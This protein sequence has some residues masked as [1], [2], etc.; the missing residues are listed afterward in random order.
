MIGERNFS[1]LKN[2][3]LPFSGGRRAS[4]KNI[5]TDGFVPLASELMQL[6]LL[7][8]TALLSV[9]SYSVSIGAEE[10]VWTSRKGADVTAQL[11]RVEGGEAILITPLLKT[12]TLKIEDL[13]LVD[14]LYL[15]E[16][17]GVDP[18]AVTKSEVG[19]PEKDA[20]DMSKTFERVKEKFVLGTDDDLQYDMLKTEHFYVITQGKIRPMDVAEVA[21]RLWRGMAFQHVN[22]REDWGGRRKLIFLV[23]DKKAYAKLGDWYKAHLLTLEGEHM[24][25]VAVRARMLWEESSSQT[26]YMPDQIIAKLNIFGTAKAFQ[27]GDIK[28]SYTEVFGAF[29]TH[30]LSG[31]LLSE[32]IGG[33]ADY[34]DDGAM[35]LR[36]GHAYYKEI[37]L[38]GHTETSL[39]D[40]EV[41]DQDEIVKAKGFDDGTKWAKTLRELVRKG[42]VEPSLEKLLGWQEVKDLTPESI[43]LSYSFAYYLQSTPERLNSFANMIRRVQYDGAMPVS[44]ELAKLYGFKTSKEFETDWTEFIKSQNFK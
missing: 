8:I 36:I 40:A 19:V 35:A 29:P 9:W 18:S 27:I 33:I 44:L 38:A 32:F 13:S 41:Y 2:R 12:V 37:K 24:R 43:V 25:D 39:L 7:A 31:T 5:D 22:F 21:E 14:R 1:I 10:R 4:K 34:A 6:R 17:G 3:G 16:Y 20:R 28:N 11:L 30:S 26:I 23:E 42:K 15:V